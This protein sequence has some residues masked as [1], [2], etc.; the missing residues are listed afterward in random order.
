MR[1][2]LLPMVMAWFLLLAASYA[3]A[4]GAAPTEGAAAPQTAPAEGGGAA[5]APQ[6]ELMSL[7][8]IVSYPCTMQAYTVFWHT[9]WEISKAAGCPQEK[10]FATPAQPHINV[11]G[12]W[13]STGF[14]PSGKMVVDSDQY[15]T[16]R[17][18]P[19][20]VL[21]MC[22]ADNAVDFAEAVLANVRKSR[23]ETTRPASVQFAQKSV[24][25]ASGPQGISELYIT[26]KFPVYPPPQG[27]GRPLSPSMYPGPLFSDSD[28]FLRSRDQQ[29]LMT[30]SITSYTQKPS[31]KIWDF[32]D[33]YPAG[34]ADNTGGGTVPGL[35]APGM[36]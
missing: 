18:W 28:T 16:G 24:Q 30:I 9:L 23:P 32:L 27:S 8:Q 29:K 20:A 19:A 1:Q 25:T 6:P 3:F 7:A 26:I 4:Q 10:F 12:L 35:M 33:K 31:K 15:M 11:G 13:Y 2:Y 22:D 34:A 5:A 21:V 17:Y 36:H 14:L